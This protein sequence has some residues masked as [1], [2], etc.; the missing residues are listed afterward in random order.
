MK[1][2]VFNQF[3]KIIFI[4]KIALI[5]KKTKD[6]KLQNEPIL[7][8]LLNNLKSIV[9]IPKADILTSTF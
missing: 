6:E 3:W 1:L 5:K 9:K 8:F 2:F 4:F 7:L